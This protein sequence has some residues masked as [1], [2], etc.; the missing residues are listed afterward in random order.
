VIP[1]SFSVQNWWAIVPRAAHQIA[2]FWWGIV[3]LLTQF[4]TAFLTLYNHA[5]KAIV[6]L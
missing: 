1:G 3:P 5:Q 4:P 2:D 6:P